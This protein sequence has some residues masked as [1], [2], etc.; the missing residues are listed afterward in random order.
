M[1]IM[2]RGPELAV[3]TCSHRLAALIGSSSAGITRGTPGECQEELVLPSSASLAT[4]TLDCHIM[5]GLPNSPRAR[6]NEASVQAESGLAYL[7]GLQVGSPRRL[8]VEVATVTAGVL[9]SQGVL[10]ALVAGE[11]ESPMLGVQTSVAHAALLSISQYIARATSS[12]TWSEWVSTSPGPEPGPPFE[13]ADGRWFELETLEPKAWQ[14]FWSTLGADESFVP[15]AWNLFRA[16]Y[17]TATCSMPPGFHEATRRRTMVELEQLARACGISLCTVRTYEEVLAEPGVAS[18][19]VPAT[20]PLPSGMGANPTRD[21]LDRPRRN[22]CPDSPRPLEG[23]RVVEAT[24]RIQGPLAG[25]LLRMLGAEVVRVEPPGGDPARMTPPV[26]G[27]TGVVFSCM[28]R[29]KEAVE[30][31]LASEN[32]RR[33]LVQLVAGADVFL[34]NW[35]PGKAQEWDLDAEALSSANPRLVYCAASGWGE[36]ADRLPPI[37]MEFLVQA[38]AGLGNA[39][40]P[41]GEQPFPTRL[42]LADFM[43]GMLACEGVL[44]GLYLRKRDGVGF[45]V[46]SSLLAGAMT[47]HSHILRSFALGE[48]AGRR[49][50][51]AV[52]SPLDRPLETADGLV[53]VTVEDNATFSRLCSACGVNVGRADVYTSLVA[54][55]RTH[56]SHEWRQIFQDAG[57]AC[58]I[59][60][61]DLRTLPQSSVLAGCLEQVGGAWM[62]ARP[63]TFI[64]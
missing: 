3:Q 6:N 18:I 19:E 59:V 8:G 38:Y 33:N 63:W 49:G 25:Q 57:I 26:A 13:A 40:N 30:L 62:T 36:M 55:L 45:V 21:G 64:G 7:H 10:A 44:G 35:R 46:D 1:T 15:Q 31:D 58:G 47:L 2:L 56:S 61:T 14:H 11:S 12:E 4:E 29:G 41:E 39:L 5:W 42:L 17:S 37:G 22:I 28:N 32:G 60:C 53:L 43:G 48:L 23:I 9:A 52:W 54:A 24:S 20:S 34:H 50:G 51:R 16:R 27:D